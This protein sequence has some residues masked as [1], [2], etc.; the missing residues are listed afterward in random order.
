MAQAMGIL[1]RDHLKVTR[2][3][4]DSLLSTLATDVDGSLTLL[5]LLFPL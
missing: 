3:R 5:H 2:D 1:G 4:A